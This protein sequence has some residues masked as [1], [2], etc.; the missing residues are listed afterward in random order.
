MGPLAVSALGLVGIAAGAAAAAPAVQPPTHRLTAILS[1][2]R[3]QHSVH[4]LETNHAKTKARIVW[5]VARDRGIQRIS[6]KKGDRFGHVTILVVNKTAYLR[7]NAFAMHV[8]MGFDLPEASRYHGRWIS[9][10]RG[11]RSYGTLAASVTLTSF[12]RQLDLRGSALVGVTGRLGSQKVIGVRRTGTVEGLRTVE[13]LYARA[14]GK[15]L[16]V[17]LIQ[18]APKKGYRDS[19]LLSQWNEPVHVSTPAHSVPISIVLAK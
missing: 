12:V 1:A 2:A 13:T 14:Y 8:Y 16:P 3:A 7:G 18:V 11:F 5:D 17:A 10:P 4:G 19:L 15:P 6:F 9:I